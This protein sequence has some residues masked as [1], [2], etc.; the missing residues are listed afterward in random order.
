[1]LWLQEKDPHTAD[2]HGG[3]AYLFSRVEVERA[4]VITLEEYESSQEPNTYVL[5]RAPALECSPSS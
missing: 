2:N 1:M 3:R 5:W 4:F